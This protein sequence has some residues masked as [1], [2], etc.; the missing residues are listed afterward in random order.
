LPGARCAGRSPLDNLPKR[1]A[2]A[3]NRVLS[4]DTLQVLETRAAATPERSQPDRFCY[5]VACD[6]PRVDVSIP[7]QH[8]PEDLRQLFDRT[9]TDES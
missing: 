8:L 4:S 6:L 1:D 2:K 7:E 5:G 9:L 3:W